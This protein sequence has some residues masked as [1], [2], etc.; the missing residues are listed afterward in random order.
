MQPT[1]AP[2]GA[3][4][5]LSTLNRGLPLLGGAAAAALPAFGGSLAPL[6]P[7]APLGALPAPGISAHTQQP[8]AHADAAALHSS[9][10]V[11]APPSAPSAAGIE[12]VQPLP[13]ISRP[14]QLATQLST[15][16]TAYSSSSL[17]ASIEVPAAP[18][19]Q[20]NL[21]FAPPLSPES[22]AYAARQGM[23]GHPPTR[24]LSSA[25]CRVQLTWYTPIHHDRRHNVSFSVFLPSISEFL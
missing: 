11:P 8:S 4:P 12:L 19:V 1:L 14:P 9:N 5:Q 23:S 17:A 2:L 10:A 20:S 7:M 6:R 15:N 24:V 22:S 18:S 3:L 13:L 25:A 16:E 21:P